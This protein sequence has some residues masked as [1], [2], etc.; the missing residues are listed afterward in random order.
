MTVIEGVQFAP[1]P[2]HVFQ[3]EDGTNWYRFAFSW[4]TPDE[5]LFTSDLWA[6]SFGHAEYMLMCMRANATIDGQIMR[7]DSDD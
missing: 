3:A 6:K 4:A 5:G 2:E 7:T 1:D